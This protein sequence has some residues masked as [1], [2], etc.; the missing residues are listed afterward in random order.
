MTTFNTG[1]MGFMGNLVPDLINLN[2]L[3][4]LNGECDKLVDGAGSSIVSLPVTLTNGRNVAN[5]DWNGGMGGMGGLLPPMLYAD[6]SVRWLDYKDC[7]ETTLGEVCTAVKALKDKL[8]EDHDY[9]WEIF[10]SDIEVFL[11]TFINTYFG[12]LAVVDQDARH[13]GCERDIGTCCVYNVT[14][15]DSGTIGMDVKRRFVLS[16]CLTEI[17]SA[18]CKN[19]EIDDIT[20]HTVFTS[21]DTFDELS[22]GS[23]IDQCEFLCDD[24]IYV[25]YCDD[26]K[27]KVNIFSLQEFKEWMENNQE[28]GDVRSF[29]SFRDARLEVAKRNRTGFCDPD[30]TVWVVFCD[31]GETIGPSQASREDIENNPEWSYVALFTSERDGNV[32]A[33][34]RKKIDFCNIA[35]TTTTTVTV[36]PVPPL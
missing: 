30:A 17:S 9:L 16:D 6:H 3:Y 4:N 5:L 7:W 25:V 20:K 1:G 10:G 33:N 8:K 28:Y 11:N 22:K 26:G 18:D 32:E 12:K 2:T 29:S 24:I 36:P 31:D 13:P 23:T 14:F 27:A 19:I 34:A 15:V 21:D 35:P